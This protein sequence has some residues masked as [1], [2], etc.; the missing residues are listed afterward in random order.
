MERAKELE[1]L[2]A[3]LAL[4]ERGQPLMT[5]EE[6]QI[7]VSEYCDE[8]LFEREREVLRRSMN[9]VAHRSQ[10]ASTGDFVT[11]DL[12]GAPVL[13]V[14]DQDE[15]VKAFLNVCRHRGARVEL[16]EQGSCRRFV[17]PYHAWTYDSGGSLLAV[18]HREGFPKLDVANSG[19][20]ELACFEASGFIWVCPEPSVTQWVPDEGTRTLLEELEGLGCALGLSFDSETRV[21]NANWKLIVDG[22][23]ESYH[24]RIAHRDTVGSFFA[25]NV[26]TFE[27]LGDHIRTALPRVSIGEL[28]GRPQSDWDIREH[29]HLVYAVFPNATVLMQ[30]GH[31]DLVLMT[32]LCVDQTRIEIASFV[33]NPGTKGYSDDAQRF[34]AANHAFTKKTLY[35]DFELA[36][37]IQRGIRSGANESFRFARF[38]GAL[39]RW[40]QLMAAKLAGP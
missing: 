8:A 32:P 40:H 7:P 33:P 5:D 31:F 34:W 28:S 18:R 24:F 25:D 20:V 37:Q 36:E 14:R 38:E 22:G 1:L 12:L 29:T 2:R 17:C 9:L 23:L 27:M 21:W 6:T 13:L 4:S 39:S 30:K 35:E 16:R 11:R 10:L 15:R 26:S 19:L 3:C